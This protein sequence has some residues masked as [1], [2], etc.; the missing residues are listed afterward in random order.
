[1]KVRIRSF[2][3]LLLP[4]V[5]SAQDRN[6]HVVLISLDGFPAYT[7]NDPNTP[8][9][10]LRKLAREGAAAQAMTPV[11]PTVT[12]PNHTTLV[13]GVRPERHGVIYNG[14]PVRQG[15]GKPLRTDP[16]ALKDT[17][18][19]TPTLY[20]AAREAGLTTAQVDWVA[21]ERAANINWAFP[22][23]ITAD[24]P[25]VKEMVAA[26]VITAEEVQA[27]PK[28]PITF[29]DELWTRAAVY[30]IE[31]HKPNFLMYHLLTTDSVQHQFGA[32]TLAANAALILA[33]RQVQR[34]LDALDRAGIRN[35]TD[36]IVISDHGFK[37]Y[38]H[39][40][41]PN[42][43][44]RQKGLLREQ[45]GTI[46][47]DVWVVAEGG[48]AMVYI[49]R[50]SRRAELALTL[51]DDLG[52]LAG[53][54]RVIQ[55]PEYEQLG[56]PK[57]ERGGRMADLVLAAASGYAFDAVTTG[58]PLV[59]VPA[60]AHLGTHGFLNS[61]PEVQAIF[62]AAGP[63]IRPGVRLGTIPNLVVAPVIARLLNLPFPQA[64]AAPPADL[65]R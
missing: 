14:L 50:D 3:L 41:R 17:L 8:L 63:H 53:V 12:W 4:L 11:N 32:K 42:A 39:L 52:K 28:S 37:S 55:P 40:I 61:E 30:I 6:R 57:V 38:E 33:D 19:L 18:V 7:F 5:L 56:Y 65:L 64:T 2:A 58:E 27:F 54:S 59:A 60:G 49:T 9:P 26:G 24:T 62:V 29:K 25:L 20:D 44:L 31:H 21:I 13:T 22:E 23:Q 48:T 51:R 35:Q 16:F 36:V 10:V 15:E 43:W 47:C 46:D 1:M 34:I 45:N